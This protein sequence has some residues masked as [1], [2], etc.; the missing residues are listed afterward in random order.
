M[1]AFAAVAF[2]VVPA[3]AQAFKVTI[4]TSATTAAE[5]ANTPSPGT[6]TFTASST[7]GNISVT[8]LDNAL[9]A[10]NVII[11]P[12]DTS[13]NTQV[14]TAVSRG[15]SG[16]LTFGT[17]ADVNP[18]TLSAGVST[19]GSQ[20]YNGAV[21]LGADTTLSSTS[22]TVT[23]ASTLDG[24]QALTIT[25]GGASFGGAVGGTTPLTSLST[26]GSTTLA[27]NVTTSGGQSYGAMML[28][29]DVA[30]TST[31]GGN[32][33]LHSTIDGAHRLTV[34]TSGTTTF[35]GAVG[36]TGA[37]SSLSVSS[38]GS[39]TLDAGVT[40]MGTQSYGGA[41]TLGGSTTLAATN[42]N[43]QSV[44]LGSNPLTIVGG[45]TL[46]G[47][48]SSTGG[49]LTKS[50]AGTLTLPAA[51]TYS[52][53]TDVQQGTLALTGSLVGHAT[54]ASG[55]TLNC[56]GGALNGGL[57]NNGGTATGAPDA[58]TG[59]SATPANG[60]ATI[61]FTKGTENCF[62]VS[63]T[64]SSSPGGVHGSGSGSPI[65]DSPLVDGTTYTFTVTATNPIGSSPASGS[66]NA[67]KP[68]GPA[69]IAHITFPANGQKFKFGQFVAT[70]FSCLDGG[71][72]PGISACTDSVHGN[73]VLDTSHPGTF[74]YSVIAASEDGQATIAQIT[75]V[76]LLP[77]NNFIKPKVH[78]SK[79][80]TITFSL[81]LPGAGTVDVL[82][83]A[84]KNAVATAVALKPGKGQFA[85]ASSHVRVKKAGSVKFRIKPNAAGR[86]LMRHHQR[87]VAIVLSIRY[88]PTQ[89][90]PRT[91]VLKGIRLTR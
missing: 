47:I 62:P 9:N 77:P 61:S 23:F 26:S 81:K 38:P 74:K 76:V 53:S 75:Y 66:S 57:T 2:G 18:I 6:T 85:F 34:T 59:A 80:G 78:G 50:G 51:N 3:E 42:V 28:V 70:E 63:Y 46:A 64:A 79:D 36:G 65:T 1:I 8:D 16:A 89:G 5:A 56:N 4:N 14:Q 19:G 33:T 21:T 31:G 91:V 20:T 68:L 11:D 83:A 84:A 39:T 60:H 10:G 67:V 41:V 25:A 48:V 54:L 7:N 22:G 73:G 49:S 32:V 17:G 45:G 87:A 72:G 69:P 55:A 24:A 58:P 86:K 30:L 90:N 37:L 52:G 40:T 71:G 35:T 43:A 12:G 44:A 27:N 13:G 88:T 29:G 15:G 82:E